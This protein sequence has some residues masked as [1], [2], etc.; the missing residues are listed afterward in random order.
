MQ[1]NSKAGQEL[2]TWILFFVGV[3]LAII[4]AIKGSPLNPWWTLIIGAFTCTAV[5]V[6]AVTALAGGISDAGKKAIEEAK[7]S[8]PGMGPNEKNEKAL[9]VDLGHS[10]P[11]A[12]LRVC[13]RHTDAVQPYFGSQDLR[14]TS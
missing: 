2:R 13:R 5:I 8:D 3:S 1:F 7:R 4:F 10:V 6:S 12:F 11:W 14:S 9:S